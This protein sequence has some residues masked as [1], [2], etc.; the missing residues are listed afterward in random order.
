MRGWGQAS[1]GYDVAAPHPDGAGIRSAMQRCLESTDTNATD[2]DWIN[3]HATSTPVGDRAEA[4]ALNALGFAA[5]E[6]KTMVSST[7]GLTGHGLSYA[8]ALEAALVVLSIVEGIV[9]G[10]ASLE[11]PDPAC[12]GLKLPTETLENRPRLVMNNSSGFG[13]SNVSHL[14]AGQ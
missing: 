11:S 6:S 8:G 4:I 1:D 12:G 9:P 3:A 5:P 2:I 10:N 7:K 13:G 14:F